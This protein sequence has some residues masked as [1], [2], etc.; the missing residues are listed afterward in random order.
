MYRGYYSNIEM[1]HDLGLMNLDLVHDTSFVLSYLING[2]RMS[3]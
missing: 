3:T 2:Q 1:D